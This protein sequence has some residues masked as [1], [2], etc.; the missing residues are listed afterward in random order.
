MSAKVSQDSIKERVSELSRELKKQFPQVA[1]QPAYES[2]SPGVSAVLRILG[3]PDVT[4]KVANVASGL[5]SEI[6]E[7]AGIYVQVR[8]SQEIWCLKS[9]DIVADMGPL[10]PGQEPPRMVVVDYDK[11]GILFVCY[12]ADGHTDH[13]FG[14]I[15]PKH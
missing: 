15:D 1:I 7:E 10:A 12:P 3:K 14:G 8:T 2:L 9:G 5:T 13:D 4:G 6:W 11:R